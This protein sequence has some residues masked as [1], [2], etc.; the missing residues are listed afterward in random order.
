MKLTVTFEFDSIEEANEQL[1]IFAGEDT[2]G[3]KPKRTRQKKEDPAN[4]NASGT[5]T[6]A[7]GTSEN[8][9]ANPLSGLV[10][11]PAADPLGFLGGGDPIPTGPRIS[12]QDLRKKAGTIA[13]SSEDK[14]TKIIAKLAELRAPDI[15]QLTDDQIN[16]FDDFLNTL[17]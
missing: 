11:G 10:S 15:T 14:K 16:I 3:E 4:I 1:N 2:K 13:I 17:K 12:K 5:V 7:T 6:G 9:G 8:T